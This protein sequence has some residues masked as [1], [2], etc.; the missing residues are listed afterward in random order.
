MPDLLLIV[1]SMVLL[2]IDGD[3]NMMSDGD[4]KLKPNGSIDSF[5]EMRDSRQKNQIKDKREKDVT[6][7]ETAQMT[8]VFEIIENNW[9]QKLNQSFRYESHSKTNLTI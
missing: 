3:I 9:S 1:M 4:G 7:V 8:K 5:P 2:N 6:R